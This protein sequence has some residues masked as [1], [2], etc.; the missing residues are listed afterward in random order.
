MSNETYY[1]YRT[2]IT[3]NGQRLYARQYGYRAWKIPANEI[4]E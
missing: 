4:K 2:Y 1:I 3:V